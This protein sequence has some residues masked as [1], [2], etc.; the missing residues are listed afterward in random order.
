MGIRIL[1]GHRCKFNGDLIDI[2]K[3]KPSISGPTFKL[4]VIR[5]QT[6]PFYQVSPVIAIEKLST[7]FHPLSII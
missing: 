3:I 2:G 4:L 5:Q 1:E 6:K 7:E